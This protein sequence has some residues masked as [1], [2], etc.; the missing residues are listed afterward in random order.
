[1]RTLVRQDNDPPSPSPLLPPLPKSP[2][3]HFRPCHAPARD[4]AD[5]ARTA[6]LPV[7]AVAACLPS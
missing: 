2:P 4:A 6:G 3:H 7:A 1:M 5:V